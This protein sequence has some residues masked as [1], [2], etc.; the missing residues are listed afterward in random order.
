M[1]DSETNSAVAALD[2]VTE[3]A[4]EGSEPRAMYCEGYFSCLFHSCWI[5]I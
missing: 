4:A 3:L 2:A 5:T 1:K